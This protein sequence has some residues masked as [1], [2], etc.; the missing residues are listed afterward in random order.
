[1]FHVPLSPDLNYA[2]MEIKPRIINYAIESEK[3][4]REVGC[5]FFY[6]K[7]SKGIEEI[8]VEGEESNV[9]VEPI[10]EE[11]YNRITEYD[12]YR[13]KVSEI[14]LQFHTHPTTTSALKKLFGDMTEED[15]IRLKETETVFSSQDLYAIVLSYMELK[16]T[17]NVEMKYAAV[18]SYIAEENKVYFTYTDA[19]KLVKEAAEKIGVQEI[20][21]RQDIEKFN[22]YMQN[23]F[24]NRLQDVLK[25]IVEAPKDEKGK[26]IRELEKIVLRLEFEFTI[27]GTS[28]PVKP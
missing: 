7:Y 2:L 19:R 1:M 24:A 15:L 18:A 22:E 25:K 10:Y 4:N 21:T 20:R 23:N 9:D 13:G 26:Y 16:E 5:I 17:L 28:F 6:V 3:E 14:I 11:L 27:G 8:C 12:R